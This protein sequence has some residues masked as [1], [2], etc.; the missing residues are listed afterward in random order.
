MDYPISR[1]NTNKKT[2]QSVLKVIPNENLELKKIFTNDQ[3]LTMTHR[4]EWYSIINTR[5][6]MESKRPIETAYSTEQFANTDTVI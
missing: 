2:K 4:F 5:Y 6:K 3:E 1:R